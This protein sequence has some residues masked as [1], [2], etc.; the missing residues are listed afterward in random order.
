[1]M[2]RVYKIDG[3]M[4]LIRLLLLMMIRVYET[5]GRMF[6]SFVRIFPNAYRDELVIR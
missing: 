2:I 5:N 1:M 3:W 4:F 6:L